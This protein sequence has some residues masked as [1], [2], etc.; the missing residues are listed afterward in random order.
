MYIVYRNNLGQV[1]AVNRASDG[2]SLPYNPQTKEFDELDPMVVELRSWEQENGALDLSDHPTD[3]D[4][5]FGDS[6]GGDS[7]DNLIF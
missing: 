3:S 1:D 7:P 4:P 6:S 2:A 5:G